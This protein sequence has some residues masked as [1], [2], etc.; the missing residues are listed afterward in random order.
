MN[1]ILYGEPKLFTP[2]RTY[3]PV[4]VKGRVVAFDG[5]DLPFFLY[6]DEEGYWHVCEET[7]GLSVSVNRRNE[8]TRNMLKTLAQTTHNLDYIGAERLHEMVQANVPNQRIRS[9]P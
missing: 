1:W 5:T 2:K 4:P 6:E 7:T 3:G 9:K 8:C